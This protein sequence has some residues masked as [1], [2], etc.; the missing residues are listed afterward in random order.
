MLQNYVCGD[1]TIRKYTDNH[2]NSSRIKK[3]SHPS[4][5]LAVRKILICSK[6]M[7]RQTLYQTH[8]IKPYMNCMH[9]C[10]QRSKVTNSGFSQNVHKNLTYTSQEK[11]RTFKTRNSCIISLVFIY[12]NPKK[13]LS[14]RE[15]M[16]GIHRILSGHECPNTRKYYLIPDKMNRLLVEVDHAFIF[17]TMHNTKCD[18]SPLISPANYV[19]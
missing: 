11:H 15:R 5:T 10:G 8:T 16:A 3:I 19:D 14:L 2:V 6:V 9:I 13:E 18:R 1:K 12:L 7:G 4:R 17:P